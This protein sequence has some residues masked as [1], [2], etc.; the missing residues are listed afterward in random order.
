MLIVFRENL[1]VAIR[2]ALRVVFGELIRVKTS[3]P[4]IQPRS[5]FVKPPDHLLAI[6]KIA[7][8]PMMPKLM[9]QSSFHLLDGFEVVRIENDDCRDIPY[10]SSDPSVLAGPIARVA[11]GAIIFDLYMLQ[12]GHFFRSTKTAVNY[13]LL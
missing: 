8:R 12:F 6:H 13:E 4:V 10:I 1:F 9:G 2:P 5:A 11:A 7:K 3:Y